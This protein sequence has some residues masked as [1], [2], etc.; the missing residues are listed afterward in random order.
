MHFYWYNLLKKQEFTLEDEQLLNL[1]VEKL[2][3]TIAAL[4]FYH[5]P[6]VLYLAY[7]FPE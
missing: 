7:I 6:A 3:V 1:F 2:P 4:H 5:L